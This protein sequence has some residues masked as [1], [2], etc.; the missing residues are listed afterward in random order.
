MKLNKPSAFIF[1][2]NQIQAEFNFWQEKAQIWAAQI[3]QF[4]MY[5]VTSYLD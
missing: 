2:P 1:A 5:A 3:S 4:E